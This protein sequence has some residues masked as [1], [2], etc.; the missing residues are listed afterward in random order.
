MFATAPSLKA[1]AFS[2]PGTALLWYE[3]SFLKEGRWVTEVVL[4]CFCWWRLYYQF[5][6]TFPYIHMCHFWTSYLFEYGLDNAAD[7]YY[8]S[9]AKQVVFYSSRQIDRKSIKTHQS[10]LLSGW[11]RTAWDS[12]KWHEHGDTQSNQL[13]Q[14]TQPAQQWVSQS[15][16]SHLGIGE[17]LISK[18]FRSGSVPVGVWWGWL[19]SVLGH[20]Q[21]GSDRWR[22]TTRGRCVS[23]ESPGRHLKW[24]RHWKKQQVNTVNAKCGQSCL[25]DKGKC[26]PHT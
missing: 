10:K 21:P 19:M 25:R 12:R 16:N 13:G 23:G 15:A 3:D 24:R 1:S 2:L 20:W 17:W 5:G 9:R 26:W 22:Q 4:R 14:L 7:F 18:L 8:T 6:Y 11:R